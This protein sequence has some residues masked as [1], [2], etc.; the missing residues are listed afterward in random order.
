MILAQNGSV[1][2]T[3]A[4]STINSEKQRMPDPARLTGLWLRHSNGDGTNESGNLVL[5]I[6]NGGYRHPEYRLGSIRGLA[7]TNKSFRTAYS[8]SAGTRVYR[9]CMVSRGR[10]GY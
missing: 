8:W 6:G 7:S 5:R 9:R 4:T 1:R 3:N 2:C 10:R